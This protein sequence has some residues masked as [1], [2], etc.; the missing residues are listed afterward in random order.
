MARR[1]TNVAAE[2]I[3][4]GDSWKARIAHGVFS[5]LTDAGDV[6]PR[7]ISS[8]HETSRNGKT[9]HHWSRNVI[10]GSTLHLHVL[11]GAKCH[12]SKFP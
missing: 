7:S 8:P 9:L 2:R 4:V 6:L 10:L 11:N 1:R 3:S 12:A 5:T